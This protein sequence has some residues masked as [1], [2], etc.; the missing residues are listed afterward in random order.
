VKK[1]VNMMKNSILLN[2]NLNSILLFKFITNFG[3]GN[4]F[5]EFNVKKYPQKW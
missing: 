2:S 5:D 4:K 1:W 3:E